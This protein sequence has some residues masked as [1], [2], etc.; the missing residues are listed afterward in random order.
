MVCLSPCIRKKTSRTARSFASILFFKNRAGLRTHAEPELVPPGTG[1]INYGAG[2]RVRTC[3]LL[4]ETETLSLLSYVRALILKK[5]TAN[6][7][8]RSRG[9]PKLI[10]YPASPKATH[11]SPNEV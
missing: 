4:V 8:V 2:G 9:L 5:D 3:D 1:A 11:F 7:R 10:I 6:L